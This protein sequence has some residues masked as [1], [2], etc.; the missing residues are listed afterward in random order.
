MSNPINI[1]P[2]DQGD[3]IKSRQAAVAL[4]PGML[5]DTNSSGKYIKHAASGEASRKIFCLEDLTVA[6]GIDDA[7]AVDVEARGLYA[8]S[9]QEINSLVAAA[10][11]AI[12]VDDEL[13]SAGDGTLRKA[14]AATLTVDGADEDGDLIFTAND[15]GVKGNDIQIVIE[16][17]T[18]SPTVV[19]E[20]LTITIT[21]D[22]TTPTATEVKAQI[23][24]SVPALDLI[25]CTLGGDGSSA[26]GTDA[27][28][29]L[30][31]GARPVARAL[32]AV[33]NSSGETTARIKVEVV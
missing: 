33:D 6:G 19:V 29:N 7:V 31:G 10:A 14:T 13:E 22:D 2:L 30:A 20:G 17:P 26:P 25:S 12:A 15:T 27:G 32:E 16:T 24:A 23:D 1:F 5:L 18:S 28:S 9:G 21:P 11:V 8:R 4:T 3:I